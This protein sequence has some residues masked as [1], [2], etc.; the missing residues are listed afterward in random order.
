MGE[1][2]TCPQCNGQR[3]VS[4]GQR[5]DVCDGLGKVEDGGPCVAVGFTKPIA[6]QYLGRS[7]YRVLINATQR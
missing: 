2:L 4:N 1:V 6:S 3:Y 5:C 7:G